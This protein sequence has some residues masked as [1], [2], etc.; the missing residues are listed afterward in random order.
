MKIV[1]HQNGKD[2]RIMDLDP[3]HESSFHKLLS[4]KKEGYEYSPLY[5]NYV[6]WMN[7]RALDPEARPHGRVWDGF[8]RLINKKLE[9]SC[10]LVPE[11]ERHAKSLGLP[12]EIE[13]RRETSEP[14]FHFS[15]EDRLKELNMV[16]RDYQIRCVEAVKSNKRGIIKAGTGA[17]KTLCGIMAVVGIGKKANIY[18]IGTDLLYSFHEDFQ[19]ILQC[20]IGIIGDGKCEIA[21]INI[22]SIWTAGKAL[23]MS[24]SEIFD[25]DSG[26]GDEKFK[27]G[28]EADVIR[29]LKAAR[30]HILDECHIASCNTITKI[31]EVINPEHLYGMSGTP[32]RMD[33]ADLLIKSVLGEELINIP[34]S[35]LIKNKVLAKPF[36]KFINVPKMKATGT[37]QELYSSYI[38][39]N[40]VRNNLILEATKKLI[41]K[42]YQTL[43][44]FN[45]IKHGEV[46]ADLFQK[47]GISFEMLNGKDDA[48]KRLLV[49]KKALNKEV[50]CLL[51]SRIF[52]IGI[53]IP[54]LSGLVLCGGGKSFTRCMQ[55]I[56]RVIR[57]YPGKTMAAIVEFYDHMKYFKQHAEKRQKYYML[58]PEFKVWVSDTV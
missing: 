12:V 24:N 34:A 30:V 22:I 58:E 37:Y 28:S 7:E 16:P 50:D 38:V 27:K 47:A 17:G 39:N 40:P 42:K 20:K 2:A 55:R 11:V 21:D 1:Y 14:E 32:F 18:V 19:N 57:Q 3:Y 54:T 43:V 13:D 35:L 9:F 48:E 6:N 26:S 44:L 56:G 41:E 31:Y 36:I 49:K 53:N 29:A 51:V 46:L 10:G 4:F 5:R 15:I 52:D 45:N 33:N 8:T 23:G 25:E